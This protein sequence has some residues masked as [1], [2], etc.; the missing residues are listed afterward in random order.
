MPPPDPSA[1]PPR[2][3][4]APSPRQSGS[5]RRG[6]RAPRDRPHPWRLASASIFCASSIASCASCMSDWPGGAGATGGRV[7][8]GGGGLLGLA[9][10]VT[11]PLVIIWP[12]RA[13]GLNWSGSARSPVAVNT[14]GAMVHC[15]TA[16]PLMAH[17]SNVRDI[18]QRGC[19]RAKLERSLHLFRESRAAVN[20]QQ[21]LHALRWPAWGRLPDR[22]AASRR[23]S[24]PEATS[25]A[26]RP[27][28]AS[29]SWRLRR[30][31]DRRSRSRQPRR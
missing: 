10:I 13:P 8:A 12:G 18:E 27:V 2:P 11:T 4:H 1:I 7:V 16:T 17:G 25:T 28:R 5:D 15:G 6:R 31:P 26:T 23:T 19:G 24:R 3:R 22:R 29:R 9:S 21:Q 30:T 20:V 14:M